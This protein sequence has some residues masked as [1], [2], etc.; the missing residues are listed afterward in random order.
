MQKLPHQSAGMALA[1]AVAIAA[2]FFPAA[3]FL[4]RLAPRTGG[5]APGGFL[6]CGIERSDYGNT[7]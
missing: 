4:R 1:P 7:V 6:G 3:A 2:A 5:M